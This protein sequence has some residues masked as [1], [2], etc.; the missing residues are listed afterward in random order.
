[1]GLTLDLSGTRLGLSVDGRIS[2]DGSGVPIEPVRVILNVDR[3]LYRFLLG[4]YAKWILGK[5]LAYIVDEI[6]LKYHIHVKV[7]DC[8]K[9]HILAIMGLVGTLIADR[10]GGEFVKWYGWVDYV[11]KNDRSIVKI[12]ALEPDYKEGNILLEI[13]N[14]EAEDILNYIILLYKVYKGEPLTEWDRIKRK[15]IG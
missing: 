2:L 5:E 15:L 3:N 14:D 7:D 1:M 8:K 12:S 13:K 6:F 10:I 9:P 4:S 11:K